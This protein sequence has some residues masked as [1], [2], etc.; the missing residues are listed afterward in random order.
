MNRQAELFSTSN[1]DELTYRALADVSAI[2][3]P[4][5]SARVIG[6]NMVLLILATYQ[7]PGTIERHT[8]DA[9]VGIDIEVAGSGNV[10]AA[11]ITAGYTAESGNRYVKTVNNLK[12]ADGEPGELVI[13]LLVPADSSRF[14]LQIHGGRAFDAM[15]GLRLA[16][17][18]DPVA[19]DVGVELL[20]RSRL[21]FTTRTPTVEGAIVLKALAHRS[22]GAAKDIVDLFNLFLVVN[23]HRE[24]IGR[25]RLDE[26]GIAGARGDAV[27]VLDQL[28]NQA[29]ARSPVAE[30]NGARL[31]ALIRRHVTKT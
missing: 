25:W 19:I 18:A 7:T 9:D 15:P 29:E 4:Y 6:G 20:D 27:R 13:D 8:A 3:A 11:L 17:A 23:E 14:V 26:P 1:A 16:L 21:D 5:E 28:A 10:H 30:V 22:R 31:A 12:T 2:I 24:A